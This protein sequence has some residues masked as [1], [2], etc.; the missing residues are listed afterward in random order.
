MPVFLTVLGVG[1]TIARPIRTTNLYQ[2]NF[3]L[4]AQPFRCYREAADA[5]ADFWGLD[6]K[7]ETEDEGFLLS[8]R[9]YILSD[10]SNRI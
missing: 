2:R 3:Q 4:Q 10:F 6:L 9:S 1:R 8:V 5:Y 7:N